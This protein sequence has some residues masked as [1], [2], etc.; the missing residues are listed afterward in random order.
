MDERVK[1]IHWSD[2]ANSDLDEIYE[3]Y[4]E[5]SPDKASQI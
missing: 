1:N 5:H 4:L 2:E 3:F